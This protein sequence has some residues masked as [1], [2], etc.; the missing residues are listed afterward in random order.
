MKIYV[1]VGE[2]FVLLTEEKEYSNEDNDV[3]KTEMINNAMNILEN[4][5]LQKEIEKQALGGYLVKKLGVHP[6]MQKSA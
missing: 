6:D 5:K 1:E 3:L 2:K 4:N